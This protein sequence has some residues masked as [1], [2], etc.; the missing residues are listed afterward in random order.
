M[1]FNTARSENAVDILLLLHASFCNREDITSKCF[2]HQGNLE[3]EAVSCASGASGYKGK[4]LVPPQVI[5]GLTIEYLCQ[6]IR[7]TCISYAPSVASILLNGLPQLESGNTLYVH[8]QSC[9]DLV[10]LKRHPNQGGS[11][12]TP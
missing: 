5:L 7:N 6:E 11:R 8:R 3:V 12:G 4:S 1:P 2:T 10:N 9:A